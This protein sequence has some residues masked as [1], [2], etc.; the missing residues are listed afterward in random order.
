[1]ENH[2][3]FFGFILGFFITCILLEKDKIFLDLYFVKLS[4]YLNILDFRTLTLCVGL[5]LLI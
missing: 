2:L 5:N 4:G 1:M 3:G